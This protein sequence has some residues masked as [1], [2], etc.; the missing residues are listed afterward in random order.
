MDQVWLAAEAFQS[1]P[2][3]A[4]QAL[5]AVPHATELLLRIQVPRPDLL[6]ELAPHGGEVGFL[7]FVAP[8]HEL[9]PARQG[10]QAASAS[11]FRKWLG[12]LLGD[13]ITSQIEQF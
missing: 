8:R 12:D 4:L 3:A 6:I 13:S 9:D 2:L 11:L 1:L 5:L 10:V 7:V